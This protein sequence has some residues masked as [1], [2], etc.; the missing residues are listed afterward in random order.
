VL[1]MS[2]LSICR[3]FETLPFE[4]PGLFVK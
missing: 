3:M 4:A 2:V 1:L